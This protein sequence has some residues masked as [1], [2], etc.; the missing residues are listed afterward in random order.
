MSHWSHTRNQSRPADEGHNKHL[1]KRLLNN[2]AEVFRA[3]TQGTLEEYRNAVNG[4][5]SHPNHAKVMENIDKRS[6]KL[7][8]KNQPDYVN[9]LAQALRDAE[10][11]LPDN[12]PSKS[13]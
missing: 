12:T 9:R 2:P 6:A 11:P 4:Y 3:E 5:V 13:R 10:P 8:L 7:A 1:A